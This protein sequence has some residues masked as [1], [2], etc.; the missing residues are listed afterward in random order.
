MIWGTAHYTKHISEFPASLGKVG[1]AAITEVITTTT[2][3]YLA[4]REWILF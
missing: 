3:R 2:T 4:L 1:M